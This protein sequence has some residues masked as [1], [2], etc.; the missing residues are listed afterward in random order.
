MKPATRQSVSALI[1]ATAMLGLPAANAIAAVRATTSTKPTDKQK[2]AAAA[3]AAKAAAAKAAAAK[4]AAAKAAAAKGKSAATTTAATSAGTKAPQTIHTGN[5]TVTVGPALDPLPET[6]FGSKGATGE[7][8]VVGDEFNMDQW[9]PVTVTIVIAGGKIIEASADMPMD[10]ARSA[11]INSHVGPYLNKQ[12]VQLQS[13][14]LD[15]ISGATR[16]CQ[17]YAE[18]LKSAM[19]KAGLT[20]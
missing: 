14:K 13:S 18:S 15:I 5:G 17:E 10:R 16:T 8:T 9:G 19:Q 1:A 6:G 7:R 3:A 4:A 11:Y 12:A 2:A 20:P